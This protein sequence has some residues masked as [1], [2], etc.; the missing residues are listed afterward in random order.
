ME[1]GFRAGPY[2]ITALIGEGGM[3]AVYRARDTRLDRDVAVKIVHPSFAEDPGRLQ[4]FEREARLLA[5]LNHPHIATIHGLEEAGG[6]RLLIMELVQGIT[7]ARRISTGPLPVNEALAVAVQIAAAIEAAHEGGVIH[8][9]LKPANVMLTP[10]GDVKVLDFGLAKA[11][12]AEETGPEAP[13]ARTR[14]SSGTGAGVM[15]GTAA[16][17]SP[18]QARGTGVDRRTDVWA[19]GCLLYEMLA[20][21]RAFPGATDS[22]IIVAVLTLEPEWIAL[23]ENV[24]PAIRRLLRRSLEKDVRRRLHDIGDARL[25]IEDAIAGVPEPVSGVVALPPQ[26][27]AG[28]KGPWLAVTA[29]AI[30]G[31]ALLGWTLRPDPPPI[32]SAA[33]FDIPLPDGARLAGLDFPAIALSPGETHLAFVASRGG[34]SQLYVRPLQSPDA[35]PIP[36]TEDALCPF[37]SPDGQWIAFF[38]SGKLK[39]VPVGGGPV[40]VL[41]DGAIGFG[42]VW[43]TDGQLVFAPNNGSSLLAVSAE[44]GPTRP[45]TTLDTA[46]GEFSHRWPELMPDGETVLFVVGTEGSWDDAQIVAQ[47]LRGGSRRVL[48]EGGTHPRYVAGRGL[49]YARAGNLFAVGL[50]AGARRVTGDPQRVVASVMESSDGAAQFSV[51]SNG[52]V[53][54]VAGGDADHRLVWVDRTGAGQPLAAPRGAYATPRLSPDGRSIALVAGRDREEVWR[55]DIALGELRQVT[56][57]GGSSPVWSADGS[58]I[59]FGASRNGPSAVFRRRADGSGGDER[60]TTGARAQ[61]PHSASP[62]GRMLAI[63]E[64]DASG[65]RDIALLPLEGERSPRPFH[66][67]PAT[68]ATPVFSRDGRFI[69]FAS[70]ESGASEIYVAAADGSGPSVRVS[71]AGGSEPRWHPEGAAVFFRAGP[72]MMSAPVRTRPALTA[73]PERLLFE[74]AFVRGAASAA[75]YDVSPDGERFLM[76][77]GGDGQ[78]PVRQLTVILGWAA[79]LRR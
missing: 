36:G 59:A 79:S 13:F 69:A 34:N 65:N 46:R 12:A 23:P 57:N 76:L 40:R 14:T 44:G 25:E 24:P 35:A 78:E 48:V 49:V 54:Y 38:A 8:R 42:G 75:A 50:D 67:S 30:A 26:R 2:E 52:S 27:A 7:L 64:H 41:A 11:M 21:R 62:D 6:V 43:G 72:R 66:P 9:D 29:A 71:R 20:G 10:G 5:S 18:E 37:F 73:G 61:M 15:L 22:D 4:R 53:A 3:G 45:V 33:H 32:R 74:G 17:M 51:S 63:I 60:V 56:F 55:Y 47:S 31:A 77:T 16:Y 28:R 19:F 70:D 58:H 1:P 68:E 39:K